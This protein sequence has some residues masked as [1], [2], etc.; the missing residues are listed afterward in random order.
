MAFFP[1]QTLREIGM[2]NLCVNERVLGS[3]RNVETEVLELNELQ[4]A[5][6]G[7]GIGDVVGH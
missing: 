5:L 7:G 2:E 6:I 3:E 1:K 4:L